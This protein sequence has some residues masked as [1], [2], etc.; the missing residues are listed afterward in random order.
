MTTTDGSLRKLHDALEARDGVGWGA[1]GPAWLRR[2]LGGLVHDE[3][4]PDVERL[5]ERALGSPEVLD[6]VRVGVARRETA[7]FGAPGDLRA[8]RRLVLPLLRTYPTVRIWHPA[9][10][11]GEEAYGTA[12]ALHEEGLLG[13]CEIYATDA[14]E[15][16]LASATSG[17]YPREDLERQAASYA[18]AGGRSAFEEYFVVD[19]ER[20]R[21]RP[22]LRERVVGFAHDLAGGDAS[23]H[24]FQLIV[25]RDVLLRYNGTAQARAWRAI[26]DSV[27]RRG[28]VAVGAAESMRH[29][30]SRTRYERLDTGE[31]VGRLYRRLS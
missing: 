24:E 30:P 17:D 28:V 3:G 20:A 2:R 16:A 25:C 7:M 5:A 15:E 29:N 10:G 14:C 22:L 26:D 23:F 18:A 27:G 31:A 21:M 1:Y 19:G 12:I 6:R 11:T 8:L 9:C 4:V 13:R